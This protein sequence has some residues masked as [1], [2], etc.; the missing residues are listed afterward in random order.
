MSKTNDGGIRVDVNVKFLYP[1]MILKGDVYT[2]MGDK[3][4]LGGRPLTQ[5]IID[6]LIDRKVAVVY[7]NRISVEKNAS[8]DANKML[9]MKDIENLYNITQE[10]TKAVQ[11][12]AP[13]PS[14]EINQIID[15]IADNIRLEE[16]AILNLIDLKEFDDYTYTHSINV[17]MLAILFAKRL[18]YPA[19]MVQRVGVAGLLH[20]EGKIMVPIEVIQKPGRL[21]REEF[22][23]IKM[24]PI[25]SYE[26]IKSTGNFH[27]IVHEA[28]LYH[29]EKFSGGGYPV[30]IKGEMMGEIAQ[31][32]SLADIFDAI[33]SERSYQPARPFWYALSQ[34]TRE[35][36]TSFS[37][38]LA[39]VF[40]NEIPVHLTEEEIF[41]R[42][43]MVLLNT[44]EVGEVTGHRYPQTVSPVVQ[45]YLNSRKE[46]MRYPIE[47]NLEYDESRYITDM[48]DEGV[49]HEKVRELKEKFRK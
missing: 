23:I 7:Y 46:P 21:T 44:G 49:E 48:V 27:N 31:I 38:R 13:L 22:R 5:E 35:I 16:G 4:C 26:I 41:R 17:S 45:I 18:N 15:N 25:Y 33:T 43:S 2:E 12:K 34:I 29:H 40:L 9:K 8:S 39:K 1:G 32:I 24:H 14:R 37:K 42:G 47:V 28:I 20:D 30:G 3:I 19:D 36:E 10:V 6:N 11:S